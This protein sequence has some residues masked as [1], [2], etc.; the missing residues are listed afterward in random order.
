MSLKA[1][2][3]MGA[4]SAAAG[5]SL[6]GGGTYASFSD[7]ESVQNSYAAGTL[8]LE[9]KKWNG[10]GAFGTSLYDSTLANLKPGDSVTK[11]FRIKNA[12]TLSIK[13]VFMKAT[14]QDADYVDGSNPSSV[15][16]NKMDDDA[17]IN[18]SADEF[19]DQI[20]IDVYGGEVLPLRSVWHG[21]L[22]ELNE[23]SEKTGD[24]TDPS[25]NNSLP[26]MPWQDTDPVR[27]VLT[28]KKDADN[29]FQ[30]DAFKKINFQFMAS[31]FRGTNYE[32]GDDIEYYNGA[33]WDAP[34]R[35]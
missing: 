23:A 17:K 34:S 33:Q 32:D 27:V 15:N 29:K 26:A 2:M 3:I 12:G 16:Y 9:L 6:V 14:Y 8:N 24:I 18:N 1:K 30:G 10:N 21:T 35:P 7:S 28:F 5:L 4:L 11:L 13:D 22:R 31:Q 19:A 25:I 20:M